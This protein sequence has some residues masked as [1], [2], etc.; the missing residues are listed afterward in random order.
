MPL[1]IKI[2]LLY[3]LEKKINEKSIKKTLQLLEMK[4]IQKKKKIGIK[5]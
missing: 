1:K 2:H 3:I 5:R 4:N